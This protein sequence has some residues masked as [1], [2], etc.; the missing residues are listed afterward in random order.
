MGQILILKLSLTLRMSWTP[1]NYVALN[2]ILSRYYAWN[3]KNI[4]Y[5]FYRISLYNTD[6]KAL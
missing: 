5:G 1:L 4:F 3:A 2:K 6:C